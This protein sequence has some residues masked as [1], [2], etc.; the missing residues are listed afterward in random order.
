LLERRDSGLTFWIIRSPVH[1]HAN[2]PF[3]QLLGAHS[4][5]PRRRAAEQRDEL[6]PFQ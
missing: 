1:E 4:N 6:A 2:P 5:R 3:A